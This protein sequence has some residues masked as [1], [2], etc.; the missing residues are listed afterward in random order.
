[1][2][3]I[4][5]PVVS[6]SQVNR[7]ISTLFSE[8]EQLNN[9]AV[10]GE[11]VDYKLYPQSGHRYFTLKDESSQLRGFFSKFYA[12]SLKFTPKNGDKVVCYGSVS[13]YEPRGDY[14]LRCVKMEPDGMGEQAVALEEL[15]KRLQQQGLFDQ[16]CELPAFPK[17]VA[18]VTSDS[19]AAVE[20]IK[21][22]ISQRCPVIKV[23]IIPAKVQGVGADLSVAEGIRRAQSTDAEV[24]I[25]GRGGGSSDDLSAFNSEVI[26]RAV[27]ASRIPTISAVGHQTDV[28]IADL[29]AD[30]RA[31]TPTEAAQRAVPDVHEFCR[32]MEVTTNKIHSDLMRRMAETE[33]LLDSRIAL[34]SAL[35]P[36]NR[37]IDV[38][39]R[40]DNAVTKIHNGMHTKLERTERTLMSTAGVISA[41]DPLGVLARGYSLTSNGDGIV[42]SSSQLK[43]GDEITVKLSDGSVRATVNDILT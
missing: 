39:R 32:Q 36:K 42:R 2:T 18:V 17:C 8:S 40:L 19:G 20:D 33:R 1:M 21:K 14:S 7:R 9:I 11:L 43:T 31:A 3:G 26:A 30:L 41:L 4:N 15:K 16:K 25:F 35:S 29:A 13:V 22:I 6:V 27:Y 38:E 10:R 24:I 37:I 34:I 28:S 12:S 5:I 23:I